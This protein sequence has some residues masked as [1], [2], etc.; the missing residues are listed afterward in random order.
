YLGRPGSDVPK[1]ITSS[2]GD[3]AVSQYSARALY[4]LSNLFS[5]FSEPPIKKLLHDPLPEEYQ[6]PYTLV[7]SLDD[8]LVHTKWDPQHGFR[9]VKRPGVEKFLAYMSQFYEI[10]IFAS[11]SC[12]AALPVIDQLDR[13]QATSYRLG[14]EHTRWINGKTVK[15][16]SYLNRDLS[17]VIIMD[18][19]EDAFSQQPENAIKLEK[20]AGDMNDTKLLD[21][22]PFLQTLAVSGISD[23]RPVLATYTGYD[24]PT[25]FAEN[26]KR[27][28]QKMQEEYEAQLAA[29]PKNQSSGFSLSSL[30]GRTSTP[31]ASGPPNLDVIQQSKMMQEDFMAQL[32]N[33]KA[34]IEQ[35]QKAM[36]EEQEQM[37]AQFK[38]KK[39]TLW[40]LMTEG[41][42]Q[43]P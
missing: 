4:R 39:Y 34:D 7:I 17:K 30:F 19:D 32:E 24:I 23:V 8:T 14:R 1:S 9:I 26:Q 38:N 35:Q 18:I 13:L 12:Q 40:K 21:F 28:V 3:G 27:Y 2:A 36:L 31:A 11:S 10:V 29:A 15:D 33:H 22:I 20:W 41:L 5:F 42:P 25:R 6:R 43:P 16:L 37:M